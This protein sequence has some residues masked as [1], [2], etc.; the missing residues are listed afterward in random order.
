MR[1]VSFFQIPPSVQYD[2]ARPGLLEKSSLPPPPPPPPPPSILLPPPPP[3]P[4]LP[5]SSLLLEQ[6]LNVS[7]SSSGSSNNSSCSSSSDTHNKSDVLASRAPRWLCP[8]ERTWVSFPIRRIDVRHSWYLHGKLTHASERGRA[9]RGSRSRWSALLS[10]KFKYMYI[11]N[12]CFYNL[13]K[14]SRLL[15]FCMLIEYCT[16]QSWYRLIF[17]SVGFDFIDSRCFYGRADNMLVNRDVSAKS[18]W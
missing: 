2:P 14:M 16:I 7:S 4:P 11:I 9:Q 12:N 17:F 8:Q 5:S 10:R 18:G 1:I 15:I 13:K 3:P 6:D